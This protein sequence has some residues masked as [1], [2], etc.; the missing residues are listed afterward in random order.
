MSRHYAEGNAVVNR[1]QDLEKRL[2]VEAQTANQVVT[3]LDAELQEE[4]PL[5]IATFQENLDVRV[6]S[7]HF[8]LTS[9]V[10]FQVS[11]REL[12]GL[13]DQLTD[14]QTRH[15][16]LKGQ[17]EPLVKSLDSVRRNIE[18]Y[19]A[20]KNQ[21]QVCQAISVLTKVVSHDLIVEEQRGSESKAQSG[22]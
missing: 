13:Q 21:L 10:V 3:R 1:S 2:L 6:F 12:K 15:L 9:T 4:Q 8:F 5:N 20:Q 17:A 16:R 18:T 7:F 19:E 14:A 11:Q 22:R